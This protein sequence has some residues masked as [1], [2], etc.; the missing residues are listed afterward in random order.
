MVPLRSRQCYN[1]ATG[2]Y[3]SFCQ[4]TLPT[5]QLFKVMDV[6]GETPLQKHY[7]S[8]EQYERVEKCKLTDSIKERWRAKVALLYDG[9]LPTEPK[10]VV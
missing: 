5:R 10:G 9:N 4:N 3:Y 1:A 7:D 6:K 2:Q 8:P